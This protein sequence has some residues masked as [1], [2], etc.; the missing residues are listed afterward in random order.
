MNRNLLLIAIAAVAVVVIVGGALFS[1]AGQ[2]GSLSGSIGLK[3]TTLTLNASTCSAP[4]GTG[5]VSFT[6]SGELRD[7]ASGTPLA[8]RTIALRT[9]RS[10]NGS[11]SV[12][13]V[14]EFATTDLN[15]GYTFAKNEPATP[16]YDADTYKYYGTAFSGDEQYA[17]CSSGTVRKL[18]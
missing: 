15:G 17:G 18:C 3:A 8:G 16:N 10:V 2:T 12:G 1:G 13:P 6:L 11:P 9:G 5:N 14:M 7:S 4:D